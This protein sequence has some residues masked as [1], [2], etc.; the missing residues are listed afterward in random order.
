M[1]SA[2]PKASLYV[3]SKSG[4][5]SPPTTLSDLTDNSRFVLSWYESGKKRFQPVGKSAAQAQL[6]LI[7]KTAELQRL[8]VGVQPTVVDPGTVRQSVLDYLGGIKDRVG[9]DG[10]GASP[11]TLAA[12]KR[13][14][15]FLLEFDGSTSLSDIDQK[16]WERYRRFL[17]TR[18]RSDRYV[19]NTLQAANIWARSIGN[20]T[21]AK[22]LRETAY[23][24]KPVKAYT[25]EQMT[26]F[27]AA[28][29]ATEELTF[30]FFLYSMCREREVAFSEVGDV[31]LDESK[32]HIQPKPSRGFRL[33]GK[34]SGQ[35]VRGRK[36]PLPRWFTEKLK[37]YTKGKSDHALLFPNGRGTVE[38]HF[39]KRCQSIARRAG[40]NKKEWNLHR[41]RK[42]GATMMYKKGIPVP[43][44]S[45]FLGHESLTVTQAYLDISDEANEYMVDKVS[46]IFPL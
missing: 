11:R 43:L 20:L 27:F 26:A 16:Y 33:K 24:P 37:E 42:T 28:C 2:V 18:L 13:R 6:A 41:W 32:L 34:K 31:L 21:C 1:E 30:R 25:E 39:L 15:G 40:L 4:Y 10:Y 17:R 14:L 9:N 29:D 8:A 45:R 19:F 44:I 23:A 38:G 35:S 22:V 12:Y 46:E 7:D 3:R 36:V 5:C